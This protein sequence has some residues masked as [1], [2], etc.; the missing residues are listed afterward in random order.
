[1]RDPQMLLH[2]EENYQD[3]S[4]AMYAVYRATH[5]MF[6]E[7]SELENAKFFS[8]KLLQKG[9]AS[10]DLKDS[11]SVLSDHQKEVIKRCCFV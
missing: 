5:L 3:F 11:P 4:G 10:E 7:E 6:V 9:L 8:K 1:M 2:M